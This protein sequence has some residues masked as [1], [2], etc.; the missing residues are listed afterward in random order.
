ME[1]KR[2]CLTC[3]SEIEN[4]AQIVV[5]MTGSYDENK[6]NISELVGTYVFHPHCFKYTAG[7]DFY[8]TNRGKK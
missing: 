4:T 3:G 1:Q 5:I 2:K 8:P 6:D 7:E